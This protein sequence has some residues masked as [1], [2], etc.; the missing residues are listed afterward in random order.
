MP[1]LTERQK[2]LYKLI[3]KACRDHVPT[4][5]QRGLALHLTA[6]GYP[7]STGAV[8]W[9]IKRLAEASL[10][11]IIGGGRNQ[12]PIYQLN[13]PSKAATVKR[14]RMVTEEAARNMER[15]KL[16]R[17][18]AMS[19]WPV[20]TEASRAQYDA[21]MKLG[22]PIRIKGPSDDARP[23]ARIARPDPLFS[24]TGNSGEMVAL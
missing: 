20:P 8:A 2:A 21:A 3:A 1:A 16:E 6:L 22:K 19:G 11:S 7:I 24:L 18:A 4:P 23:I 12:L 10:L 13:D 14:K 9:E 17:Q 15:A 5:T